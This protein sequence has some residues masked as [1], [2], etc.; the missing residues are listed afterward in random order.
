VEEKM[1][2]G[3]EGEGGEA[4]QGECCKKRRNEKR[5]KTILLLLI[6]VCFRKP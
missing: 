3:E 2:P 1:R 4:A 6:T 5:R